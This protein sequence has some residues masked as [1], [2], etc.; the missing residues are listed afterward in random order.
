VFDWTTVAASGA[1]GATGGAVAAWATLRAS[2]K[3]RD[4]ALKQ[5]TDE[6]ASQTELFERTVRRADVDRQRARLDLFQAVVTEL[7]FNRNLVG[8]TEVNRA[9]IL[10]ELDAMRQASYELATLPEMTVGVDVQEARHAMLGY[11]TIAQAV[12]NRQ[13]GSTLSSEPPLGRTDVE[14]LADTARP[15]IEKARASLDA[16]VAAQGAT[17]EPQP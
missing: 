2:R 8:R 4:H 9:F 3:E 16:Y 1:A 15:K 12:N 11:N 14:A 7:S 10:F 13:P 17:P 6:R 5:A